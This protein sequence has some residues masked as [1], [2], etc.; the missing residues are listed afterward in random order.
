MS[1]TLNFSSRICPRL[2]RQ[3]GAMLICKTKCP[4]QSIFTCLKTTSTE[5]KSSLRRGPS[6]CVVT[7]A[8]PEASTLLLG[9]PAGTWSLNQVSGQDQ[10]N[11]LP[12]DHSW[13]QEAALDALGASHY[14]SFRFHYFWAQPQGWAG[15][16]SREK[17]GQVG[18]KGSPNHLRMPTWAISKPYHL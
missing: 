8:P 11:M 16:Y 7:D 15:P 12:Q 1:P 17:R 4:P 3:H 14:E 2:S 10:E 6:P 13:A 9:M 18:Q 5:Q